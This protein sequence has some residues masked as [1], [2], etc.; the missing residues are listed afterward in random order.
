MRSHTV[1][2][3][4][5]SLPAPLAKKEEESDSG[6]PESLVREK[7]RSDKTR[8]RGQPLHCLLRRA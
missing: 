6:N 7:Q 1:H 2:S 3:P 8:E 5:P 4:T